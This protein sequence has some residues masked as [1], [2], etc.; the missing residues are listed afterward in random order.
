M[1]NGLTSGIITPQAYIQSVKWPLADMAEHSA[2]QASRTQLVAF[3]EELKPSVEKTGVN[4]P[5]YLDYHWNKLIIDIINIRLVASRSFWTSHGGAPWETACFEFPTRE[6]SG[7][8]EA[9]DKVWFL[10]E[11]THKKL[12]EIFQMEQD[13]TETSLNAV[14]QYKQ[15]TDD[16]VKR[17]DNL[18]NEATSRLNGSQSDLDNLQPGASVNVIQT[19]ERKVATYRRIILETQSTLVWR[20]AMLTYTTDK[21]KHIQQRLIAKGADPR[22]VYSPDEAVASIASFRRMDTDY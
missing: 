13:D 2:L 7:L 20:R 22:Q 4:H 1:S 16:A 21:L 11:L 14:K 19:L 15:N 3:C 17:L 6:S 5:Q 8:N 10:H 12:R 18:V 9:Q